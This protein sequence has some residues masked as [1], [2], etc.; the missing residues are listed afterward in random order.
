MLTTGMFK[1]AG[2]WTFRLAQSK[3]WSKSPFETG[4]NMQNMEKS[5][6]ANICAPEGW[7]IFQVDQSGADARVVAWECPDGNYR[8]LFKL[9]IKPHVFIALIRYG[10]DFAARIPERKE[11][12][13]TAMKTPMEELE[14]LPYW[15]E[16]VTII[17]DS[18]NW[19]ADARYYF[20]AKKQGHM[21]NYKAGWRIYREVCLKESGGVLWLSKEEAQYDVETYE[22]R[23]FPEI[24]MDWH[25][26][27]K[28]EFKQ[29][30][31]I[32][33]NLLGFPIKFSIRNRHSDKD[34]Y[35]ANPQS[36]VACI[37]HKAR[38]DMQKFIVKNRVQWHM[39]NNCHD[40]LAGIAPDSEVRDAG[41][42]LQGF[43]Q[44]DLVSTRGEPFRMLSSLAI[45]K[46]WAPFHPK[47]NPNGL[48]ES[49]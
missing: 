35:A 13:L 21:L 43:M 12:F 48:V 42:T 5:K 25:E 44:Q 22:R 15:K 3:M 32:I 4:R 39:F 33:Y 17:S 1:T 2:P 27:V 29:N 38:N 10:K 16:L 9:G 30:G 37:S 24:P 7:S 14:A 47:K 20:K 6:R 26:R 8:K 46:N 28:R 31:N 18:D 41:K 49:V 45:G 40:S 23:L 36:T 19:E 11:Q 34:L